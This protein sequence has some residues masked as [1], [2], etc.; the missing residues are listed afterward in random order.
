M[1]ISII[2]LVVA[3]IGALVYAFASNGKLVEFG[4]AL[5]WC[6]ILITL[7]VSAHQTIK[8]G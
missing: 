8:V 2:P 1:L 4:R 7:L 5:M 3:V 6:G